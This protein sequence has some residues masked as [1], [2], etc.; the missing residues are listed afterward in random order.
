MTNIRIVKGTALYNGSNFTPP[1]APLTKVS[2]TVLLLDAMTSATY[3]TDSS[4]NGF[5]PALT[6]GTLTWNADTP[7]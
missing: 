7:Y 1:T 3:L 2:G 4:T 5:T 6:H